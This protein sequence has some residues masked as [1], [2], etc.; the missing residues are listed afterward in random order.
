MPFSGFSCAPPFGDTFQCE[1]GIEDDAFFVGF[2]GLN[3]GD[4]SG[5]MDSWWSQ[6]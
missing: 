4:G 6:R 3:D 1:F 5:S 2:I